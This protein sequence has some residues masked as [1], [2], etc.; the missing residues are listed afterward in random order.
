VT[1]SP[2]LTHRVEDTSARI[3]DEAER[4][5]QTRGFNAFSYATVAS[6]LGITKPAL[7]Y[8]FPSKASLGE[9]MIERYT[10]RF[11]AQLARIASSGASPLDQLAGYADLYSQVLR[12]GRLCL[13]G[14]LAADYMTLPARMRELVLRFFD[15]NERWLAGALDAGVADGSIR[16]SQPADETARIV[17]D[18]LEGAMLVARPYSDV[19]RFDRTASGVLAALTAAPAP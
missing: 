10:D 7:H 1:V 4:L 5:V 14:M 8:H 13:C 2:P 9:A 17:I 11:M 19:E 16:I 15:R 18:T 3:L 12:S 6:E